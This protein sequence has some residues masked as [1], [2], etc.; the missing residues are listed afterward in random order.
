MSEADARLLAFAGVSAVLI[1]TPGP[2]TALTLRNAVGGGAAAAV[3]TAL[4]VA[5]GSAAWVAAAAFGV[6]ALVA[7]PVA[8]T[9]LHI[10]GGVYLAYLGVGSVRRALASDATAMRPPYRATPGAAYRSGLVS[11]LLNPK[12]AAFFLTLMPAF[13]H[14]G[15]PI[16]RVAFMAATYEALLLAWLS[17]YGAFVAVTA[18]AIGSARIRR[19]LEAAAG[20]VLVGLAALLVAER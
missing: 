18:R 11:N 14:A 10:G 17:A 8:R 13:I 12:A 5:T 6:A 9:A 16:T 20:I 1:M 2:D 3:M 4:G 19:T 15:D 7:S